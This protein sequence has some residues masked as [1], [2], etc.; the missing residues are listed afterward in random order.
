MGTGSGSNFIG[1]I[2]REVLIGTSAIPSGGGL[3]APATGTYGS[4][5]LISGNGVD[6]GQILNSIIS[7]SGGK[8]IALNT[9]ADGWTITG[10]EIGNDSRDSNQWDGI[11]AQVARTTIAANLVYLSGGSGID[12]Y[13]SSGGAIV[14]NNTV[15]NNGQLCTPDTGEP[16]GIRSYGTNNTIEFNV[17]FHNYGAGVLVQATGTALISQNSIYG[18]GQFAPVNAPGVAPSLQIGID[19]LK[20]SDAIDHGTRPYVTPNDAGDPDIG[21]NGLLNFPVITG[22]E[23]VNGQLTLE[24]FAPPGST[25]ELF[26]ADPDASGFGQGKTY[27]FSFVEGSATDTDNTTGAYD[28]TTLQTFGY[29]ATVA[30]KAGNETAAN[31][32]RIVV[33]ANGLAPNTPI[34]TTAT[35]NR[36]TSE[37]SLATGTIP[38]NRNVPTVN[39]TVYLDANRNATLDNQESGTGISGLFVKAVV[40]GQNSAARAVPVDAATGTYSFS[41]LAAG[42]YNLVLDDNN[43][44][45]DITPAIP[46]NY[47]G[48]QAPNGT[49]QVTVGAQTVLSQDFG[50]FRGAQISGNVFE[51]Q[52]AGTGPG[53]SSVKVNLTKTDGTLIDSTTT[54]ANGNF[55][56]RVPDN[57]ASTPLRVVEI[58][59]AGF[60]SA[61]GSAGTTG[62]TYTLSTDTIQFNY[63]AGSTYTG[64]KFGDA[65][66]V[67]FTGEDSKIGPVGSSVVYPHVF[68]AQTS[69]SVTFSTTQL[70]APANPNWS[71]IAYRDSNNN[72]VLDGADAVINGP[73]AVV[74]GA[75]ITIFLKNFIP[76]TVANGAQDRLTITATFTP[77]GSPTN[78][79]V[80][81]LSRSDLTTVATSTGLLLTKTVDKATAR[82]GDI[83]VYTIT[84]RNT[85]AE[86][87]TN[88]VVRDAMP[89]YT[90]FVSAANGTL[91]PGLDRA[92]HRRARRGWHGRGDLDVRR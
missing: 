90:T 2:I 43:T 28:A 30:N 77:T 52:G 91:A 54:D 47:V 64:L 34:A 6:N 83:L 11:D 84:Y 68:T 78:G 32:F 20:A 25:V 46:A 48:T 74:A 45:T 70:P 61:S 12:S 65:R 85:G 22:Y 59:P 82:S 15:R 17:V 39:G 67:T 8:G 23:I 35:F 19:L 38:I 57:L 92:N 88:L 49:R 53:L 5:D 31:R 66:G 18:N 42:T 63:A 7:Y 51:D 40:S 37:F 10:N 1:P 4:G 89:A 86:S 73:I 21:A 13:S 79:P 76:T 36:Q 58:N 69:G 50:V 60:Q 9:G 27:Q 71:V 41:N 24:G 81:T 44:L 80:Q 26:A 75:P 33:P 56:F 55:S 62:G 29:S 72:G 16:A 14:R 87:L 3:L